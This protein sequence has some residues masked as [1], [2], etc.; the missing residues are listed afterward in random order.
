VQRSAQSLLHRLSILHKTDACM[1]S[2]LPPDLPWK[3]TQTVDHQDH[4]GIDLE[5]LTDSDPG[6][7]RGDMKCEAFPNPTIAVQFGT[8]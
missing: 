3:S 8:P 4:G 7:T 6:P 1:I 5:T 2:L